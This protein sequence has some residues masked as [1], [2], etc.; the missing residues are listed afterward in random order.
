MRLAFSSLM[1]LITIKQFTAF[2]ITLPQRPFHHK[3]KT[4]KTTALHLPAPPALR[5]GP[6]SLPNED[7]P[8]L[9]LKINSTL[10]KATSTAIVPVKATTLKSLEKEVRVSF[11]P[12]IS[13]RV[14]FSIFHF[15]FSNTLTHNFSAKE[16][17]NLIRSTFTT[18][19]SGLRSDFQRRRPHIF[20]DYLDF[21]KHPTQSFPAILFLYFA[22]LA[23]AVSFGTISSFL[24][25]MNIGVVEFLFSCG[26]AGMGY[27]LISGQPMG[28]I[29]PTGLTLAFIG[30]L[31]KLTEGECY[32]SSERSDARC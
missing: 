19:F 5:L 32:T 26:T 13:P 28:F 31:F 21:F 3:Y 11:F 18:P 2:H 27:S 15:P 25:G 6:Q 1:L 10:I 4:P 12:L 17:N 8:P 24:T 14:P 16:E 7:D 23:P 30:A 20:S 9:R 29:A 22:C